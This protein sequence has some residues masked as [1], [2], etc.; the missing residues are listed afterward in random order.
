MAFLHCRTHSKELKRAVE[1]NVIYPLGA[2]TP[3]KVLYLLHGLSD[4][5]SIWARRTSIER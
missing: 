4:D 5:A 2:G 3:D 1:V